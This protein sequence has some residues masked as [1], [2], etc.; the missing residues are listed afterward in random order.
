MIVKY[1][2]H[3]INRLRMGTDGDGIR[4]LILMS[5]CPLRCKYC[6]NPS[7]WDGTEQSEML[8]ATEIY[9][10]ICI[11][12][13]YILATNGGITFGGGEPLLYPDLINELRAICESEMTICVES[14]LHVSWENIEKTIESIDKYYVDIKTTNSRLYKEYTGG[15]LELSY[16][17]IQRLLD[18]KPVNSIIARIPLIPGFVDKEL[19]LET[20]NQLYKL[21]IRH[22]DLFEYRI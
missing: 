3:S 16:N 10:R 1:P 13:P 19:Q 12:R 15:E 21:G 4:T 8:S 5:G 18:R 2:V 11:D 22:F 17:N 9:S 7:T 14:S 20:K 6:I